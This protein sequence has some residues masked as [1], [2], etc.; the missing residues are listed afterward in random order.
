MPALRLRTAIGSALL[1]AAL[2]APAAAQPATTI[3]A[4]SCDVSAGVGLLL[5][6]RQGLACVFTPSGGGPPDRYAGSISEYGIALGAVQAGH[7]VWG[8]FA[9]TRGLPKGAL[10]GDYGGVGAQASVG[11]GVGANALLGGTGR[12]FT[13]QPVS[14]EGQVGVNVAAGI[15]AVTLV[16]V[17]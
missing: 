2:S 12:S 14:I 4:L 16:S 17:P 8:V 1:A 6:Q 9:P 13:L 3:G 15:T 7:L 10:A 5:V 11:V